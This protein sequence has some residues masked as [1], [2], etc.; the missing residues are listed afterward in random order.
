MF[1]ELNIGNPVELRVELRHVDRAG[2][3]VGADDLPRVPGYQG[4][5]SQLLYNLIGNA[6]KYGRHGTPVTVTLAPRA[7]QLS[8]VVA[9]EGDGIAPEHLPRLT[10]RFYRVDAGRSRSL[11]G[12]G[13]GLAI[14]KHVVER[15]RGRLDIASTVGVG[16]RVTVTLPAVRDRD[17]ASA[18]PEPLS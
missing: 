16:T 17:A 1:P 14:V 11:G 15:H 12:T 13:L 3:D 4:Q 5:L 7:D 2:I 6:M 18:V 10:E 9:D 8:V